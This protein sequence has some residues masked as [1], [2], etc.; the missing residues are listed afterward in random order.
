MC[1]RD[2]SSWGYVDDKPSQ[3]NIESVNDST[4]YCISKA[5]LEALFA[6][7]LLYTSIRGNNVPHVYATGITVKNI[8]EARMRIS[9]SLLFG[10]DEIEKAV[11]VSYT[12]LGLSPDSLFIRFSG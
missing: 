12:H 7:C 2:S 6:H 10:S 9:A 4:A 3:V 1:I 5:K 11:P 8:D